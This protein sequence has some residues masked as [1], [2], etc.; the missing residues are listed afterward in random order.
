[1]LG[2]GDATV[3]RPSS[4]VLAAAHKSAATLTFPHLPKVCVPL[5]LSLMKLIFRNHQ[6]NMDRVRK[7]TIRLKRL[8]KR[9]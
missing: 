2:D 1:M 6:E 7:V 8:L 9:I 5:L 3:E 4:S